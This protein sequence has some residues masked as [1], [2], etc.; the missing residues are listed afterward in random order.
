MFATRTLRP[1]R[2]R[3]GRTIG[4]VLAVA[5]AVALAL[6]VAPRAAA[7]QD[8][9]IIRGTVVGPDSQPVVGAQVSVVSLAAQTTRTTRTNDRGQFTIRK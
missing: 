3:A 5:L 2:R 9:D 8:P 1:T 6:L 7:A 4:H